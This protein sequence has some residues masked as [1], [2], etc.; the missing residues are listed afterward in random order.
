M[1]ER[2]FRT[3]PQWPIATTP[4][5]GDELVE[6]WKDGKQY[7][8]PFS[9]LGGIPA[10]HQGSH[11]RGGSDAVGTLDN[12][13]YAIPYLDADG[14]IDSRVSDAST[15][16]KGK[17]QLAT[18]GEEDATKAV[19]GT[20]G[21]LSDARPPTAHA[22]QHIAGTD[23]IDDATVSNS[24]LMSAADKVKADATI[25]AYIPTA[26]QKAA[27]AGTEGT[28]S[29]TNKYVTDEDGRLPTAGEKAALAGT[30]GIP[31]DT[32][33]YVTT[34]DMR[35]QGISLVG[36]EDVSWYGSI[37]IMSKLPITTTNPV[38]CVTADGVIHTYTGTTIK[39]YVRGTNTWVLTGSALTISG[40]LAIASLTENYLIVIQAN[41]PS[42]FY[43]HLI[44]W[45]GSSYT[46]KDS[47]YDA[48]I[49]YATKLTT[50]TFV[51][52][53]TTRLKYYEADLIAETIT[54][55]GTPYP[56]SGIS[57]PRL[58]RIND[59]T[60]A[61]I[62]Y[63]NKS[64]KAFYVDP[65]GSFSPIG[66]DKTVSSM[67]EKSGFTS[68]S[69]GEVVLTVSGVKLVT[70]VFDGTDWFLQ[71][72]SDTLAG[73]G[74]TSIASYNG[75]AAYLT[76]EHEVICFDSVTGYVRVYVL[77]YGGRSVTANIFSGA[78]ITVPSSIPTSVKLLIRKIS[79][80]GYTPIISP[81]SGA[82][83]EGL[84]SLSLYGQYSF[85]ELERISSTVFAVK[86]W[87]DRWTYTPEFSFSTTNAGITYTEQAGLFMR[88]KKQVN[89]TIRAAGSKGTSTGNL[90][91]TVPTLAVATPAPLTLIACAGITLTPNDIARAEPGAGLLNLYKLP[92]GAI[93]A[94]DISGAFSVRGAITYSE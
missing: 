63:G 67:L 14:L 9:E 47:I 78:D 42:D 32:N 77:F 24:G 5:S 84:A 22:A 40:V 87:M 94:A 17:V 68:Y 73:S 82:T 15:A 58:T 27:L 29:G 60:V 86:E 61:F 23:V 92:S 2:E 10:A 62:D 43:V 54:Q 21:R 76:N 69:S 37:E 70:Y 11:Q 66:N 59:E 44:Y 64:L 36:S 80:Y 45:D 3:T 12:D 4:L 50:G 39:N 33:R 19:N 41:G 48:E 57:N 30:S 81:P 89:I 34:E 8:V 65:L 35:L 25:P 16:T 83:F 93:T 28:A 91:V 79:E 38:V 20:D 7:Y 52:A 72:L 49:R 56:I 6:V 85:V 18:D 1:A 51:C 74:I 46:I 75:D 26:D 88:N 55:T 71:G 53:T 90:R 31:S 13:A